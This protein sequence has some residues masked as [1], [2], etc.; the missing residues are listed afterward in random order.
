MYYGPLSMY[1]VN[2]INTHTLHY[3]PPPITPE[4][5]HH[6]PEPKTHQPK[7]KI[8]NETTHRPRG[9]PP[10]YPKNTDN[11]QKKTEPANN[12]TQNS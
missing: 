7:P 3:Q 9:R 10:K 8:E 5:H 11:S 4:Q 1:Q 12:L 6:H 2:P